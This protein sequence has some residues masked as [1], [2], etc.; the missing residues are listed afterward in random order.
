MCSACNDESVIRLGFH[1]VFCSVISVGGVDAKLQQAYYS[2]SGT[3]LD[4]SAPGVGIQSAYTGNRLVLGDGTSQAAAITS[5]VLAY[6]I[7][8]G[9]TTAAGGSTW[10][11][12]DALPLSQTPERV[13]AG[14]VQAKTK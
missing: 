11:Q 4:I 8:S 3:G 2:N 12:N 10:L 1:A 5:G 13:G 14:M 9:A 6:G 7:S